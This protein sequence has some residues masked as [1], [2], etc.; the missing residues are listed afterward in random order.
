MSF[1][2]IVAYKTA[3]HEDILLFYTALEYLIF[4]YF[5]NIK[6]HVQIFSSK[7]MSTILNFSGKFLSYY[8]QFDTWKAEK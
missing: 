2:S 5:R 3:V 4:H 7:K 6:L 8:Q 1:L